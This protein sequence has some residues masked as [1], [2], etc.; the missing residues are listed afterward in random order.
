MD[1][2]KPY[3]LE[4]LL[5]YSRN[6]IPVIQYTDFDMLLVKSQSK[7]VLAYTQ[8]KSKM[9]QTMYDA[10]GFSGMQRTFPH[11]KVP[12]IELFQIKFVQKNMIQLMAKLPYLPQNSFNKQD[13]LLGSPYS[14]KTIS[15]DSRNS[16]DREAWEFNINMNLKIYGAK[17]CDYTSALLQFS[18]DHNSCLCLLFSLWLEHNR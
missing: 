9:C 3:I 13:L 16:L 8:E 18:R 7:N 4:V 17:Y 6:Y 2:C 15:Q 11:L 12:Q 5:K 10:L 14:Y 1:G